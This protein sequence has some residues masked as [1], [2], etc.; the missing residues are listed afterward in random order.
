MWAQLPQLSELTIF[1]TS[2]SFPGWVVHWG[3]VNHK[4]IGVSV[5]LQTNEDGGSPAWTPWNWSHSPDTWPFSTRWPSVSVC[6]LWSVPYRF[7][8]NFRMPIM[9]RIAAY[10]SRPVHVLHNPRNDRGNVSSVVAILR[11]DGFHPFSSS[12]S[13]S[14]SRYNVLACWPIYGPFDWGLLM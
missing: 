3:K 4:E 12:S 11:G 9:W 2:A 14:S 1:F 5:L 6:R 13:S 10:F 8:H 7:T